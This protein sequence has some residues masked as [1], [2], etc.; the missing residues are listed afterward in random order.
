MGDEYAQFNVPKSQ[1]EAALADIET[2]YHE[3]R[4]RYRGARTQAERNRAEADLKG[5][6]IM[7]ARVQQWNVD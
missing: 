2:K 1:K 5:A 6:E 4:A 3:A 7:R